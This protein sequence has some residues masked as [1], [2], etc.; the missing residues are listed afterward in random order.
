MEWRYCLAGWEG[1]AHDSRV[2]KDALSRPNGLK[3]W[4]GNIPNMLEEYYNMKHSSSQNVI[5]RVMSR[6]VH[7]CILLHNFIK[8]EVG[9][10]ELE[11]S[12]GHDMMS[13][14]RMLKN[15]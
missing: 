11:E 2:L 6:I 3:E 14:G 9:I 12:A 15:I 5:E 7:A 8:Q 1:S 4:G 10:D 13:P